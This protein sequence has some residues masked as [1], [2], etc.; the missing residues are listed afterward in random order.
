MR[1]VAIAIL[2]V[3]AGVALVWIAGSHVVSSLESDALADEWP[4]GLGA[5]STVPQRYPPTTESD[6]ARAIRT[7]VLPAA[8]RNELGT[9]VRQEIARSSRD[10][11]PLPSATGAFLAA[12]VAELDTLDE[13]LTTQPI[14]WEG[15]IT[16][17]LGGP[18]PDVRHLVDVQRLFVARALSRRGDP[19]AWN[20]LRVSWNIARAQ[21]R[22]HELIVALVGLGMARMTNAAARVL[23]PPAPAWRD[24][25]LATDYSRAMIAVLQA[26]TWSVTN[27]I[28]K[29]TFIDEESKRPRF[30]APMRALDFVLA[31][32]RRHS[33]AELMR[34]ERETAAELYGL[35]DC[36]VPQDA[37][38]RLA[39]PRISSTNLFGRIA[40]PNLSSVWRRVGRFR[41]E[42]ELTTKL[43]QRDFSERSSCPDGQWIYDGTTLRFSNEFASTTKPIEMPLHFRVAP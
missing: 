17:G 28:R 31:P 8:L 24:E 18:L 30:R 39:K 43:L 35:R 42:L 33:A 11:A 2:I 6:A 7:F 20:D 14:V 10:V 29:Y 16:K 9:Y 1:R 15:D 27:A 3:L 21:L 37:Y 34:A 22:R 5:A 40:Y 26:D 41:I 25:M 36:I 23:P 38:D 4:A 19:A 13:M 32:Y 12:N